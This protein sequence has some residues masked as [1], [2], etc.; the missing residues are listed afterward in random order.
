MQQVTFMMKSLLTTWN[1]RLRMRKVPHAYSFL[2]WFD[3][4]AHTHIMQ[5]QAQA[6]GTWRVVAL[7]TSILVRKMVISLFPNP[8]IERVEPLESLNL[9][10][11]SKDAF[12]IAGKTQR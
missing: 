3:R 12:A 8:E 11:S 1:F 10:G 2:P 5:T 7:D 9:G 4:L 6:F